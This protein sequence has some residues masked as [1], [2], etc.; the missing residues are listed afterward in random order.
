MSASAERSASGA[1]RHAAPERTSAEAAACA[2]AQ[3]SA[4]QP[5]PIRPRHARSCARS[6]PSPPGAMPADGFVSPDSPNTIASRPRLAPTT[7]PAPPAAALPLASC[8]LGAAPQSAERNHTAPA[9]PPSSPPSEA[10]SGPP[11]AAASCRAAEAAVEAG[12]CCCCCCCC[13][14]DA[15]PSH[16]DAYLRR[17]ASGPAQRAVCKTHR[18]RRGGTDQAVSASRDAS[19][20]M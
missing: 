8:G 3:C 12:C 7:P 17:R 14:S 19:S 11:G 15:E 13:C 16:S 9:P 18:R 4:A 2:G 1:A 5:A 10:S 20:A 6:C